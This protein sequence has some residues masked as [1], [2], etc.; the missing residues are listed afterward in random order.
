[1]DGTDRGSWSLLAGYGGR[2]VE[3]VEMLDAEELSLVEVWLNESVRERMSLGVGGE[4]GGGEYGGGAGI[5]FCCRQVCLSL[6]ILPCV[7]CSIYK[8]FL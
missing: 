2:I 4:Y 6:T 3:V 7:N 1:M 8:L 5:L